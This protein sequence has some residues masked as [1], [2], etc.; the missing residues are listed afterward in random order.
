LKPDSLGSP[1]FL[2]LLA[3][4]EASGKR[5]TANTEVTANTEGTENTRAREAALSYRVQWS[6]GPKGRTSGAGRS[7]GGLGVPKPVRD[8]PLDGLALVREI[9]PWVYFF[10]QWFVVVRAVGCG[11]WAVG[12]GLWAV[13]CGLWRQRTAGGHGLESWAQARRA[14]VVEPNAAWL[15]VE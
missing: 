6:G 3:C 7:V 1:A 15:E 11:L 4:G 9:L 8:G 10:L 5:G 13:G 12:C 2:W 14:R